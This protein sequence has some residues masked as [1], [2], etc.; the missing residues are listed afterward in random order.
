MS[1]GKRWKR[2]AYFL[3]T[4]P[5]VLLYLIFFAF[6]VVSGLF[7]SLTDWNGIS[8]TFQFVGLQN[9]LSVF[10][11]KLTMSAVGRT[12]WYT[13]VMTFLV[14]ALSVLLAVLLN[15]KLKLQGFWR[16]TY[17]FPA[18]MSSITIGL[19][20]NQI[21]YHVVPLVGK[22]LGIALLSKNPLSNRNLAM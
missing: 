14:T 15:Q 8:P 1:L 11:D 12:F 5:A 3:F 6:P 2:S 7:Y 18:V 9:Y 20:F 19:I 13:L 16:V 10:Q 22:S 21:Y 4:V 17:F